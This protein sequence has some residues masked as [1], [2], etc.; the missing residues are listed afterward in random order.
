[1]YIRSVGTALV[2]TYHNS[3][4]L[5]RSGLLIS[6]IGQVS[7][8]RAPNLTT[9][10]Q[11][12]P[13][14]NAND[15]RL[16]GG[17]NNF[18]SSSFFSSAARHRPLPEVQ[19]AQD[20]GFATHDLRLFSSANVVTTLDGQPWMG[21]KD[22]SWG[23]TSCDA[24]LIATYTTPHQWTS[25]GQ[26][27][28]AL[29]LNGYPEVELLSGLYLANPMYR[30]LHLH[31][32]AIDG[33]SLEFPCVVACL[34][35]AT[36]K[37]LVSDSVQPNIPKWD[38]RIPVRDGDLVLPS[39][40]GW[41]V[42]GVLSTGRATSATA[43]SVDAEV[44]LFSGNY[45]PS[46]TAVV[47]SFLSFI[48]KDALTGDE[49]CSAVFLEIVDQKPLA[50]QAQV[51]QYNFSL[52]SLPLEELYPRPTA[53]PA[54]TYLRSRI[55][56]S[57]ISGATSGHNFATQ[58]MGESPHYAMRGASTDGN[59]VLPLD[60]EQWDFAGICRREFVSLA[61]PVSEGP[62]PNNVPA[63]HADFLHPQFA[64]L[65]IPE[66]RG[67]G[68]AGYLLPE[69]EGVSHTEKASFFKHRPG[70]QI[71]D[72]ANEDVSLVM[73]KS[74]S[75]NYSSS[76]AA[77]DAAITV[78]SLL[79]G[80]QSTFRFAGHEITGTAVRFESIALN[81]GTVFGRMQSP[82]PALPE[83]VYQNVN[84]RIPLTSAS[85]KDLSGEYFVKGDV[86][87]DDF[88]FLKVE[89]DGPIEGVFRLP[90]NSTEWFP[91]RPENTYGNNEYGPYHRGY[92]GSQ[93]LQAYGS[94]SEADYIAGRLCHHTLRTVVSNPLGLEFPVSL[95]GNPTGIEV[96][97][98][99]HEN[100][101]GR[102]F[103]KTAAQ[104]GPILLPTTQLSHSLPLI[105]GHDYTCTHQIVAGKTAAAGLFCYRGQGPTATVNLSYAGRGEKVTRSV[106]AV[107]A[108]GVIPRAF[109][110]QVVREPSD[111]TGEFS[112]SLDT[113]DVTVFVQWHASIQ[114]LGTYQPKPYTAQEGIDI[115][116]QYGAVSPYHWVRTSRINELTPVLVAEL[117][118]TASGT[119]TVE[120]EFSYPEDLPLDLPTTFSAVHKFENGARGVGYGGVAVGESPISN[121][122][123]FAHWPYD[124]VLDAGTPDFLTLGNSANMPRHEVRRQTDGSR[125]ATQ[126]PF[127]C[128]SFVF[129]RSQTA[130]LLN[131]EAVSP[132]HWMEFPEGDERGDRPQLLAWHNTSDDE[133]TAS[134]GQCTIK[135]VFRLSFG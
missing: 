74:L 34:G 71:A 29:A 134:Y 4:G 119:A 77:S 99:T 110:Q 15:F 37:K 41:H 55:I 66:I 18:L 72:L 60:A 87:L 45:M 6:S 46:A 52:A 126:A 51:Y 26:F 130:Q 118:I 36:Y 17:A 97:S 79:Q 67:I 131:G 88:S 132:T 50:S 124:A 76:G 104:D 115:D 127:Y 59:T 24:A 25:S 122:R 89:S 27:A 44:I 47:N 62:S 84:N 53:P 90:N 39:C 86:G 23:G 63:S 75:L 38:F 32:V 106:T 10:F 68:S 105:C 8:G 112:V 117:W 49:F 91:P 107:D 103:N 108:L 12:L 70:Q 78:P 58:R 120:A 128:G 30:G 95:Q 114:G 96:M 2:M 40:G 125:L 42:S 129:N 14:Q 100:R 73:L 69:Q 11:S 43:S 57:Q 61:V 80:D 20:Y 111:Y 33:E 121:C 48:A 116:N 65:Q 123:T 135:P 54:C 1:M 101:I 133:T 13:N 22:S 56:S 16:I 113:D 7:P 98:L 64:P 28:E 35:A 21:E 109:Y 5:M 31:R 94:Y 19:T 85:T 92:R 9:V 82:S 93:Q 81:A 102:V 3:L 83:F